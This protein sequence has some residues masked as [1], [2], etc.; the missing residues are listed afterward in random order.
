MAFW[1][2]GSELPTDGLL[3]A[4]LE[5]GW[6]VALPSTVGGDLEPR[7]YE[8]GVPMTAASFGAMEPEGGAVDPTQIDIVC[9]PAAAFDRA[10]RRLGYGGGFYDRFLPKTRDDTLRAGLSFALQI[11]EEVPTGA[12]D[13]GVDVVVTE[14]ETIRCSR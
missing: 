11:V 1:S 10:G 4:L 3:K 6:T 5:G 7:R 14:S 8:P 12:F 9:T 2:F 13:L